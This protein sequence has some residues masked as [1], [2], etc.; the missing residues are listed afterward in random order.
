VKRLFVVV[1]L[2]VCAGCQPNQPIKLS[3]EE[4]AKAVFG[5]Y[6][7]DY[8]DRVK[9]YFNVTLKDPYSA[10]YDFS[11]T[12]KRARVFRGIING[13]GHTYGYACIVGVNAKNSFGGYTGMKQYRMFLSTDGQT[14]D[15][16]PALFD[17]VAE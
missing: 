11:D 2:F 12:P 1:V 15:I 13:G 7:T 8:Q 6:P 16:T 9:K 4:S 5:V 10:V 3:P 14:Y 17:Y